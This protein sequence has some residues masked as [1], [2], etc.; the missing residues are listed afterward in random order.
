MI[1]LP[2]SSLH[3]HPKGLYL[4]HNKGA[5]QAWKT[6][7]APWTF[8]PTYQEKIMQTIARSI[9][10]VKHYA[11]Y[12]VDG[13]EVYGTAELVAGTA[14]LF[15][16]EGTR[17]ALLVSYKDSDLLLYGRCDLVEDVDARPLW[18]Q[19]ADPATYEGTYRRDLVRGR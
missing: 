3:H 14:Y 16:A 19:V 10:P 15:R 7:T 2:Y 11:S 5:A 17:Q 18:Q 8:T 9:T 6:N 4:E 1:F 13:E 12:V